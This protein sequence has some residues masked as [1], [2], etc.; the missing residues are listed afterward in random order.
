MFASAELAVAKVTDKCVASAEN[1]VHKVTDRYGVH[2][3]SWHAAKDA[4]DAKD[5]GKGP[6]KGN[7]N[8][9][10]ES[11]VPVNGQTVVTDKQ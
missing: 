11:R 10:S 7:L 8:L 2:V 4:E 1:A 5:L 3:L 9:V 6:R